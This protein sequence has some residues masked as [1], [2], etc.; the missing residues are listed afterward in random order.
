MSPDLVDTWD[1]LGYVSSSDLP[2]GS[3]PPSRWTPACVPEVN[4]RRL[5]R[6]QDFLGRGLFELLVVVALQDGI[7]AAK[8]VP[9]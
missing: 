7:E 9:G 6:D 3:G 2:R 4:G 1:D 5:S 8:H